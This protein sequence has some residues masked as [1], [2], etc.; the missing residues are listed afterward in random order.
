[1]GQAAPRTRAEDFREPPTRSGQI[2]RWAMIRRIVLLVGLVMTAAACAAV[3]TAG[4]TVSL[5][6]FTHRVASAEV[7]LRWNCLQPSSGVLRV[8]GVAHNPWQAQPI[9][10]LELQVVG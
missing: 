10:Y 3:D 5:D 6:A 7:V 9:G 8:D 1:M 4:T 2:G